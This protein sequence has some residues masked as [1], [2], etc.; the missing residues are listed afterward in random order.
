MVIKI[1]TFTLMFLSMMD[2]FAQNQKPNSSV[3]NQ[4]NYEKA[5][6]VWQIENLHDGV[7]FVRLAT[8]MRTIKA[9]RSA[10]HDERADQVE[11]ELE[12]LNA[13]I[14]QGFSTSFDFCNVYFFESPYSDYVR[15]NNFDKVKFVDSLIVSDSKRESFENIHVFVAEFASLEPDTVN[16]KSGE[17]K[18]SPNSNLGISALVI[19]SDQFI[20]LMDPF[21]YYVREY[22]GMPGMDREPPRAIARLNEKLHAFYAQ[23]DVI[24]IKKKRKRSK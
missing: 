8:K 18:Q 7:I 13:S 12:L 23:K 1:L 24:R 14:I 16:S 10:G 3:Y 11:K 15:E 20:Q 2:V 19:K 21:P 17:S 22:K 9:L 6:A 4:K 5:L